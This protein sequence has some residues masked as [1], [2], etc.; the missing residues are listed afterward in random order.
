MRLVV[1]K[2]N[3]PHLGDFNRYAEKIFESGR[4]TNNGPLVRELE[5]RIEDYL[6]V[7]H[8]VLVANGTLGL[9]IAAKA[10]GLT[11]EV[12][13]P[14]WTF[15]ATAHAMN[16][17]GLKPVFVDVKGHHLDPYQVHRAITPN[18]SAI[19]HVHTWGESGWVDELWDIASTQ[20]IPLIC[21]AAHAFWCSGSYRDRP[22]G[23]IG[24]CEVFSF[25][26]TK[27]FGTFEGGAITTN[28]PDLAERCKR[29]RN[30][31][32]AD[33]DTVIDEG[34]NAKMSEIHAAMGLSSWN[35]IDE[36][37][38]INFHNWCAYKF[39]L[40]DMILDYRDGGIY[41]YQ[42]VVVESDHRDRIVDELAKKNIM[43][44]KYF[45]PGV[46]QMY[47]YSEQNWDLPNTERLARRTLCLPTGPSVTEDDINQICDIVEETCR[48]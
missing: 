18:T 25:H 37:K 12:I 5:S 29:M 1:G 16:W 45:Y 4:L 33:Y 19:L 40:D 28:D 15:V 32:F 9:Q 14:G 22:I 6:C 38:N 44:R 24:N 26:A 39:F 27:F 10:L 20:N 34:T 8:C 41:N 7:K 31:G 2:P 23:N 3:L 43:A 17:I 42:Y 48:S 13:M 11:G 46:H 35:N 30:F 47:P 21:D 36:L